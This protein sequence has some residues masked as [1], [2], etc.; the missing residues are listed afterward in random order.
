MIRF[1]INICCLLTLSASA[2]ADGGL[3]LEGLVYAPKHAS[4]DYYA[5]PR[6]AFEYSVKDPHTGDNKAQWEKRDGDVVKGAYSLVEPD[7]SLRIVEYWADD[8]SGF[9]AVVK[10]VGPNLHPSGPAPIYKAQIPVLSGPALGPISIGPVAKLG[11]LAGAPLLS[12]YGGHGGYGGYGGDGGY[13]G[14]GGYGGAVS[15][16]SLVKAAPVAYSA[17]ILPA[18]IIKPVLPISQVYSAPIVPLIKG[19]LNLGGLGALGYSAT[20]DQKSQW[21]LRD[22][23]NVKGSYSLLE[24]DGSI[25]TVDYTASDLAGFNA[26]VKH[27][28]PNLHPTPL[29]AKTVAPLARIVGPLNYGFGGAKLTAPIAPIVAALPAP[30]LPLHA[31]LAAPVIAPIHPSASLGKW[32]LPWDPITHSYGGWVPLGGTLLPQPGPYATIFSKKLINGK[33]HRWATGPIPLHGQTLVIRKK[34]H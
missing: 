27:V 22:G 5:Y 14:H 4:V 21:E 23:G 11:G 31:A 12:V 17:P 28:G 8:K 29:I 24:P 7:G 19:P 20:N 30:I 15:T 25:R 32:S 33:V 34:K 26:V 1:A 10:R 3:G 16:A 18:P 6:Y 2:H 13:G 9:N